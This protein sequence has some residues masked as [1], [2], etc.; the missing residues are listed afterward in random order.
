MDNKILR[1]GLVVSLL[2]FAML[3]FFFLGGHFTSPVS[4]ELES[5]NE[6][7]VNGAGVIKAK[8]DTGIVNVAVDTTNADPQKA[9]SENTKLTNQLVEAL[10]KAGIK[11]E[12]IKTGYYNMYRE[13][14]YNDGKSTEGNYRVTHSYEVTIKDINKVGSIIDI[15]TENGANQ[16]NSVR[17]TVADSSKYYQE[18][19]KAA[20]KNAEEKA[21]TIASTISVK[22]GKPSKV[23]EAGYYEPSPIY[24]DRALAKG[25]ESEGSTDI[26]SGDLEIRANVQV[27]YNY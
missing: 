8:P 2:T 4:A 12:D 16:V 25:M 19:L 11:E 3:G 18:A 27:T 17:F 23:I 10:K 24:M 13:Y 15:A 1:K 21:N 7:A 5:R 26:I 20:I 22:I 6:I 14:N 9:Q